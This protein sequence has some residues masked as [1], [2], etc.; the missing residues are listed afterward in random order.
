MRRLFLLLIVFA[1]AVYPWLRSYEVTPTTAAY[2]GKVDGDPQYGGVAE[3]FI[4]NYDS[5]CYCELF[6]GYLGQSSQNKFR[7]EIW[8]AD[9]PLVARKYD[10][11]PP[12]RDHKWLRFNLEPVTGQKFVRGKGYL[13]KWCRGTGTLRS[14][15]LTRPGELAV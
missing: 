12:S 5:V 10:V 6:V 14:T 13:V 3:S 11:D 4:C 15:T 8:E 9:G 1:S 7:A 2:S